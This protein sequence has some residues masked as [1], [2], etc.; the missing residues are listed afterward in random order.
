MSAHRFRSGYRFLV[1]RERWCCELCRFF[2]ATSSSDGVE[3]TLRRAPFRMCG[4]EKRAGNRGIS[5]FGVVVWALP[6]QP[7]AR[8]GPHGVRGP[9][10]EGLLLVWTVVMA[11]EA[12]KQKIRAQLRRVLPVF[13]AFPLVCWT[14][15]CRDKGHYHFKFPDSVPHYMRAAVDLAYEELELGW[16]PIDDGYFPDLEA[17]LRGCEKAVDGWRALGLV[18]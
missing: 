2:F 12:T 1:F 15:P 4:V 13:Q 5:R 17:T 6:N 11:E 14:I 10:G 16:S 3:V 9:R 8:V 7:A 18:R